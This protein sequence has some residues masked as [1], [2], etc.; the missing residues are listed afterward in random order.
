MCFRKKSTFAPLCGRDTTNVLSV[1]PRAFRST[2]LSLFSKCKFKVN[3]F[4]VF[5]WLF[6]EG[7]FY[8]IEET[9]VFGIL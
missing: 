9:V 4:E 6:G 8:I 1:E 2:V 3:Y 7:Q 5:H